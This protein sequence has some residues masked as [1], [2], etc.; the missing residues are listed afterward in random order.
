MLFYKIM[1]AITAIALLILFS[2]NF[3]SNMSR[4][5]RM[6]KKEKEFKK[7]GIEPSQSD[8]SH[9]M[10]IDKEGNIVSTKQLNM[11]W[12]KKLNS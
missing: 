1:V 3:F 10:A 5:N 4:R 7:L 8:Y 6:K 9:G 11:N 12:Y 2:A